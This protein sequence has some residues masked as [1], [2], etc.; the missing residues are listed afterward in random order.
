[1]VSYEG[2][3]FKAGDWV[4]EGQ[5]YFQ[6]AVNGRCTDEVVKNAGL[7]PRAFRLQPSN[8]AEKAL[9]YVNHIN[10]VAIELQERK[11]GANKVVYVGVLEVPGPW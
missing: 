11:I 4:I 7:D 6:H 10:D 3:R 8:Q 5:W 2:V 1:M 9:V